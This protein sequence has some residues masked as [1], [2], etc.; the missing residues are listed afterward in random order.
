MR[1][2]VVLM[3]VSLLGAIA[4]T[5]TAAEKIPVFVSILPQK[6]FVQQIGKDL[7]TV[8]AMVQPGASPH[9]YEPRPRQMADISRTRI[10]FAI[11]VSFEN[12][13]L[14]KIAAANPEMT[15]VHTDQGIEKIAMG[16]HHHSEAAD[17]HH[18][19]ETHAEEMHADASGRHEDEGRDPHIWLS[20]A[21]VKIQA[22]TVLTALQRV[23]PS[24]AA[25]YKANYRDFITAVD[26]LDAQLK[27]NFSGRKGLEF[28]VFHPSWGYFARDYGL[29]EIPVEI[30]GKDP[31]PA[32]LQKVIEH[33]R[34]N[35]IKVIFV[36]PQF[37]V[38]SARLVAGEID[39]RVI[40]ADPLAE[41]WAANLLDVAGKI[42]GTDK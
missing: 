23:D 12:V 25:I 33:A 7:V 36:Q 19:E 26:A 31:K 2:R 30:E 13:W 21:L 15:V 29:K 18:D 35:K 1:F 3:V 9:T 39:G 41:D 38:K 42:T 32:Q 16:A 27:K 8:Q 5:A 10:Y 22:Q 14:P 40:F 4:A 34:R 37:S 17:A 24:H 11:G 20:P 28:M 6:Y